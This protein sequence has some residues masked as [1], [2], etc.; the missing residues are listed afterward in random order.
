MLYYFAFK[1]IMHCF[2]QLFQ[3]TVHFLLTTSRPNNST[4]LIFVF[5]GP[6]LV[7]LALIHFSLISRSL[8][9]RRGFL[10]NYLRQYLFW[11][12]L[13]RL[14]G[15]DSFQ[16]L[17]FLI[18]TA[19]FGYF[20]LIIITNFNLNLFIVIVIIEAV[21]WVSALL[22]LGGEHWQNLVTEIF[23]LF[24]DVEFE[25]LAF[26]EVDVVSWVFFKEFLFNFL[27][28]VDK[29]SQFFLRNFEIWRFK[30]N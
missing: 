3:V 28:V 20:S 2:C 16:I 7:S 10:F 8:N 9:T 27:C 11:F 22:I 24:H 1:I 19:L 5:S 15:S 17:L 30:L 23:E 18:F 26:H 21:I 6:L 13:S 4:N 29:R 25:L 14:I 12:R